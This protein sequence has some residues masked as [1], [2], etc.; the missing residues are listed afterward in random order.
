MTEAIVVSPVPPRR[1]NLA[2]MARQ[3]S[4]QLSNGAWFLRAYVGKTQRRF[5]LGHKRDFMSKR[6][7]REAADRKL[8]ELRMVSAGTMAKLTLESFIKS[9]FLP[10]VDGS[11]RPSTAKGYRGVYKRYMEG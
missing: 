9:W 3:G 1:Y 6:A 2:R 11:L 8:I 5:L 4:I 10:V 7:V